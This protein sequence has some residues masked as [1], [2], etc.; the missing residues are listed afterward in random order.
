MTLAGTISIDIDV[1]GE[2]RDAFLRFSREMRNWWPKRYSWSGEM[3][4]D[5]TI[6]NETGGFCTEIGPYGFRCDFGR[7][8]EIDPPRRIVFT[9]QIGP[10]R[11][12][13][14]DPSKASEVEV[15]FSE[16]AG[17]TRVTLT[18]RGFSNHGAGA[19]Q[20]LEAMRS[21]QGWP[22]ILQRFA[23]A[24]AAKG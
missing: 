14:P 17:G 5:M 20:Y 10:N 6:A 8:L 19:Q 1:R 22:L 4:Q 23:E 11:E 21:E 7:V 13:V 15:T 3:L 12:P 2:P 16:I 18:H 9:W 24:C